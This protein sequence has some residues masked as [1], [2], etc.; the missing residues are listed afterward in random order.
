MIGMNGRDRNA[1]RGQILDKLRTTRIMVATVL[2]VAPGAGHT[3][4]QAAW[5]LFHRV[6]KRNSIGMYR[7]NGPALH[8]P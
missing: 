5:F 6:Y 7:L 3:K 4:Y 2:Y 1:M 8:A